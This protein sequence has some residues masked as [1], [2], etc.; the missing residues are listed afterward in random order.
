MQNNFINNL[1]NF[2]EYK[3]VFSDIK[4]EEINVHLEPYKRKIA[5][6]SFC[7]KTHSNQ[8]V[9]STRVIRVRDL[10]IT[11]RKVFLNV[12]KR[13]YRC[14][15][16]GRIHVEL[17]PWL[18][19]YSRLTKRHAEH[20]SRLAAITTNTEAGW[21]LGLDDETV[22]RVDKAHLEEEAKKKLEPIPYGIN[23]SVDEVSYKKYNNYL[24]NV[25][26]VDLKLV[27]WNAK[28]RKA[29]I[30][31]RFYEGI[32]AE[33][34]SKIKTV[35]MDGARTFISS[36]TRH[37]KNALIVYDKF[38]L[39]QKLNK[40]VDDV[41]KAELKKA[42]S[43]ENQEL[44]DM[45]NCKRR[46]LLLKKKS[47]LT[48]WQS[49]YLDQLCEINKPIFEALLLKESF[50][51]IYS[52]KGTLEDK[53]KY[54]TEWMKEAAKSKLDPFADLARKWETK[55]VYIFNWFKHKTSSA[56]SEGFNN[57]IKRLKR[58]AYGYR[59]IDYFMLKIHQH[60]GLLNPRLECSP[61]T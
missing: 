46:F 10:D 2:P 24:T 50:S 3:V 16:D 37:A 13:K 11:G 49:N 39:I 23:L 22:Y 47:N 60:C 5:V 26:D 45:I 7:G 18:K 8:S 42:R 1:L 43:S 27:I 17:I 12:L 32:G 41:R 21:F 35:A 52:M 28:G 25:I 58:M 19:L 34:C 30:L 51:A 14:P 55:V 38:H 4:D 36:T 6:C 59:D 53:R 44:I 56:I 29:E 33:N 15:D 54:L 40:T 61:T 20:V 48:K 57:K 9:H 31:D